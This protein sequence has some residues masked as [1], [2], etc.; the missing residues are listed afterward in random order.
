MIRYALCLLLLLFARTILASPQ[1]QEQLNELEQKAHIVHDL[2]DNDEEVLSDNDRQRA[3]DFKEAFDAIMIADPKA[4]VYAIINGMS[5]DKITGF[6]VMD[7]G[8]L[9]ILTLRSGMREKKRVIRVEDIEELGQ[10]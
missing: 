9:I 5:I 7:N 4:K 6:Q 2:M 1:S 3:Q 8:T 10:R